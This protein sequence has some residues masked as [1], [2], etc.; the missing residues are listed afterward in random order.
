M[1]SQSQ[2]VVR[3]E[4]VETEE[5][6]RHFNVL[7]QANPDTQWILHQ[8]NDQSEP[9]DKSLQTVANYLEIP[10]VRPTYL[11]IIL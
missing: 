7:R 3:Q 8:A 11:Y 4:T 10:T 6:Q 1:L 2:V 5:Q 9:S